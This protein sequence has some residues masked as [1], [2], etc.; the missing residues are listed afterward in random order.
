M[1]ARTQL[2]VR[3]GDID[4]AGIVYYPTLAHYTHLALEDFFDEHLGLP[5]A[6]VLGRHRI[7]LPAVHLAM[8]FRRPLRYG[9]RVEI[10]ARVERVGTSSVSW[11]HRLFRNGEAEPSVEAE[12]VT[13]CMNIETFAKIPIP[14]WLR[15]RMA[16]SDSGP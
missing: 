13:V 9:D 15:E 6:E 10:E 11:R 5:Y 1:P 4:R 7:G 3:F 8:R 14:D 12:I 16:A 2:K